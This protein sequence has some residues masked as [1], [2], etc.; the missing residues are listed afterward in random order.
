LAR[1][2]ARQMKKPIQRLDVVC[3]G[4]EERA[5]LFG[6]SLNGM[7]ETARTNTIDRE[8]L[9][10]WRDVIAGVRDMLDAKRKWC[11]ELRNS[12]AKL[13]GATAELNSVSDLGVAIMNRFISAFGRIHAA[14][15]SAVQTATEVLGP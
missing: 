7:A 14:T 3:R 10:K 6:M 8:V 11:E 15:D 2:A 12:I 4:F 5:D 1:R 13:R 9:T